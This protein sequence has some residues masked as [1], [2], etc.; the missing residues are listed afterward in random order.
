MKGKTIVATGAT[1]GIGEAAVLA[2]AGLGAR[3]VVVARDEAR[4]KATM[5]KLEAKAPG[6]G[7]RLHLAD[8]SSMAETRKVGA[9]IAANEPRIDVLINN[10]GALFSDRRVTPEGLELT[11]A[12]NHMA[13]FVL[14]E[15]LRDRLIA[16]APARIVST[17]SAA[18]EGTSLDFGDLQSAKG[19]G[20]LKVYGRSKLANILFTRELARRLAGTGVTANCLHPGVV[21]TRFGASSGGFAG[22]LIPLLRGRSS[23]RLRRAP[24]RSSISPLR[25]RSPRRQGAISSSARSPSRPRRRGD[26]RRRRGCGS[27]ARSCGRGW[28]IELAPM[29]LGPPYDLMPQGARKAGVSKDDPVSVDGSAPPGASFETRLRRSSGRGPRRQ[30]VPPDAA[31]LSAR[32]PVFAFGAAWRQAISSA[33]LSSASLKRRKRRASPAAPP[34][35]VVERRE[36]VGRDSAFERLLVGREFDVGAEFVRREGREGDA[37]LEGA[38]IEMRIFATPSKESAM[39]R[40][41]A[42]LAIA[43]SRF[44]DERHA[45]SRRGFF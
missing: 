25:R 26:E 18:H 38:A 16:S 33:A 11:F 21:A 7:H 2:L 19:Y 1:S 30:S 8:L 4:A 5:R 24:T 15:A 12:L 27:R 37:R 23:S 13:Y 29:R 45:M 41:S 32:L 6:L 20:G 3:I 34:P 44:S 43:S 14:T 10:A 31:R 39:R 17:S 42:A 22:L 40:K 28:R 9:A 36:G 35:G